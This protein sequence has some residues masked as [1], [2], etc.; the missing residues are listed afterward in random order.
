METWQVLVVSV[1]VPAAITAGFPL[2][3]N[4]LKSRNDARVTDAE[5]GAA[6]RD[7]LRGE[8][9]RLKERLTEA[10]SDLDECD[11]DRKDL[12]AQVGQLRHD[13]TALQARVRDGEAGG[14]L[15]R[16]GGAA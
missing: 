4:W 9:D 12:R 6:I 5:V 14:D 15:G 11:R 1:V 10:E 13:L 2:F 8:L 7:E 16:A 3:S